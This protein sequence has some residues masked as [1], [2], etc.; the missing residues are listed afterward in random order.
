MTTSQNQPFE[1]P[2]S[3]NTDGNGNGSNVG[4]NGQ[5]L[6][7]D[8]RFY[9]VNISAS[10]VIKTVAQPAAIGNSM[11][12]TVS[13]NS[14]FID[15]ASGGMIRMCI[16]SCPPGTSISV[17]VQ[18]APPNIQV[19]GTIWGVAA[20]SP[21]DFPI[22]TVGSVGSSSN[23]NIPPL[24][25][26]QAANEVGGPAAITAN[27]NFGHTFSTPPG[28]TNRPVVDW[29]DFYIMTSGATPAAQQVRV[30]I[31]DGNSTT[32]TQT[33]I[34]SE[35]IAV[36]AVNAD[37][38]RVQVVGPYIGQSGILVLD[39]DQTPIANVVVGISARGRFV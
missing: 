33:I 25:D 2:F 18:N 39:F 11:V 34:Y 20:A 36:Q 22:P 5:Q 30:R 1:I 10:A 21:A 32:P 13:K 19:A 4:A 26:F 17:K 7:N 15:A 12:W 23:V 9:F 6:P 31:T 3:F 35:R 38:D 24:P 8:G 16:G 29:A 28:P 14:A 27:L 37:V